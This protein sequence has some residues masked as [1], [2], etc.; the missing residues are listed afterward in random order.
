MGK[1]IGKEL[2]PEVL[3]ALQEGI[4]LVLATVNAEGWPDTAPFSWVL[5]I[6]PTTIRLAINQ[7][8]ATLQNIRDNGKVRLQVSGRGV[9][10]SVKGRATVIKETMETTPFPTALVEMK[11]EE[12]KDDSVMGRMFTTDSAVRW[13]GA[14]VKGA[15]PIYEEIK[16]T[17]S[18]S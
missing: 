8:I 13:S 3:E 10:V 9:A 17:P 15:G 14:L 12:V 7:D 4:H 2:P 11:V 5:G 18:I 6:D 1:I 16:Q